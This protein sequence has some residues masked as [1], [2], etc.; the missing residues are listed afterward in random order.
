LTALGGDHPPPGGGPAGLTNTY[1]YLKQHFTLPFPMT[2]AQFTQLVLIPIAGFAPGDKLNLERLTLTPLLENDDEF[3][4]DVL[5]A[6]IIS[7]TGLLLDATPPFML[8]PLNANQL[9]SGDNP[10]APDD[11]ENRWYRLLGAVSGT[12][13]PDDGCRGTCVAAAS[14]FCARLPVR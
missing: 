7:M 14:P 13:Q 2:D 3:F 10:F 11:Y 8:Y 1:G 4:F 12:E 6:R 9:Q 5:G